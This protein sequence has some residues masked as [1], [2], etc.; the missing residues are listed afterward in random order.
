MESAQ[1]EHE[2]PDHPFEVVVI[3]TSEKR[4]EVKPHELV[5]TL[6]VEALKRFGIPVDRAG[7][8]VL[9]TAPGN[10]HAILDDSK[11]VAQAGLH[12][13]S[14]IYLEKPHNDA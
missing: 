2:R 9:A 7:Q 8:Y 6:K 11:T 3:H 14:R 12:K 5:G 4:I 10:P 13:N 1:T